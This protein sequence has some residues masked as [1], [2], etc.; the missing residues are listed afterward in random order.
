MFLI[1]TKD[2]NVKNDIILD[3]KC[4]KCKI[5]NTLNFSI[6]SRY[7]YLTLIPLFPVGKYVNIQCNSCK[8]M[9]DYEDLPE[10]IQEKLKAEKIK[11]PIWMFS[12]SIILILFVFFTINNYIEK[13][14]TISILI[15]NPI[16]GDVYNL[17]L[18][19]GYYSTI[20]IDK[21]TIDS[22]Y[23]TQNDLNAYMPYEVD[24]ID[25]TEN[26]S[27]RKVYYSK[28]DIIKLYQDDEIIEISRK[29]HF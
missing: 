18:P 12:G 20:K 25:K 10:N 23:A 5:D 15:K 13:K 19:N 27:N 26:Y 28:K 6:F 14:N 7:T 8:E 22:I 1:G 11:N 17:K 2:L 9:F 4:P 21:V 29:K 3:S 24:D 16:P